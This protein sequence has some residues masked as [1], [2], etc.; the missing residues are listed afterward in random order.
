MGIQVDTYTHHG[1]RVKVRPDLRGKHK[2]HCL[3]F[4]C[5]S[6]KPQ[7]EKNCP[8]AKA[9]FKVCEKFGVRAPVYECSEFKQIGSGVVG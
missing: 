2:E 3:C 9:L 4:S 7:S 6:F 8:I 1:K 5:D